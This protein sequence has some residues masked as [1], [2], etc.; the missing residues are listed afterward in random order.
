MLLL[1]L[2]GDFQEKTRWKPSVC[3]L[4]LPSEGVLETRN[5]FFIIGPPLG[6]TT[7]TGGIFTEDL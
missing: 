6:T 3:F 2:Y 7:T 5:R 4:V 1:V